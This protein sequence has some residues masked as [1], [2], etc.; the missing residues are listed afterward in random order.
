[1]KFAGSQKQEY[2][3]RN[4]LKHNIHRIEFNND[5]PILVAELTHAE[6]CNG[7]SNKATK[8]N[9]SLKLPQRGIKCPIN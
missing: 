2:F 9:M 1:M 5:F 3:K 6:E 8:D 4:A 7:K